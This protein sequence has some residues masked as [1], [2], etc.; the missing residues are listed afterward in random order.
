M[1]PASAAQAADVMR[2]RGMA[3]SRRV[4]QDQRGD[5]P[6]HG[7]PALAQHEPHLVLPGVVADSPRRVQLQEEAGRLTAGVPLVTRPP[8]LSPSPAGDH[9]ERST[10]R[11][12]AFGGVRAESC[13]HSARMSR[14]FPRRCV[15]EHSRLRRCRGGPTSPTLRELHARG[16][17]VGASDSILS[18]ERASGRVFGI[19]PRACRGKAGGA[20]EWWPLQAAAQWS[21]WR[22]SSGRSLHRVVG[23]WVASGPGRAGRAT[24]DR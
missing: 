6:R 22:P 20:P 16:D 14:T 18:V 9:R 24:I 19:V 1:D 8:Q 5:R 4:Q 7:R 13:D 21:S 2:R 17:R 10:E 12:V 3:A 11:P 15:A 23:C